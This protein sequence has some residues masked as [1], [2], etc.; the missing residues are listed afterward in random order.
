MRT[1][2]F[3]ITRV[4][5]T[6]YLDNLRTYHSLEFERVYLSLHEV[7]DT[8]FH[9]QEDDIYIRSKKKQDYLTVTGM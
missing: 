6:R 7:A 9:I 3:K 4:V 5:I 8:P 1:N 2:Q